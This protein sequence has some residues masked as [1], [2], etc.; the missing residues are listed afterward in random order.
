MK[1]IIAILVFAFGLLST[2][3]AKASHFAA[4]D[5]WYEYLSPLTYKVHVACYLDCEIGNATYFFSQLCWWSTSACGTG[6]NTPLGLADLDPTDPLNDDTLSQ[7]CAGVPNNCASTASIYPAFKYRHFVKTVV[8]S[9]ACADWNFGVSDGASICTIGNG[10][11]NLNMSV[12]AELNNLIRPINNSPVFTAKPIPYVCLN[13][14]NVYQNGP[15]D[16]DLDSVVVTSVTPTGGG[17][18]NQTNL[19]WGTTG[20]CAPYNPGN[21]FPTVGCSW[22]VDPGTG[23][24]SFTPSALGVYVMSFLAEDYDPILNVKVGSVKRDVQIVVL[25]CASPPPLVLDSNIVVVGGYD[26][27]INGTHVITMCPGSPVSITAMS[28]TSTINPNFYSYANLSNFPAG[29]A[30]YSF[31]NSGLTLDTVTGTFTFT[32]SAT[33]STQ[34]WTLIMTFVDSTCVPGLQP[35][36]LKSYFT[37]VLKVL[38][39]V[40]GGG[41]Y[42]YCPGSAPIQLN[43]SGPPQITGWTWT[44]IPG[45]AGQA[46]I[47]NTNISN[48]IATPSQTIDVVVEGLPIVTGCPNRDTV[49]LNVFSALNLNCG[50]DLSPCAN[51]VVNIAGVSNRAGITTWTPSTYLSSNNTLNTSSTPLSNVQYVCTHIDNFGCKAIDTVNINLLGIR[52][53]INSYATKDTVCKGD[54]LQLFANATPQPCGISANPCSGPTTNKTIGT[55]NIA[56]SLF[57]PFFRDFNAGYRLQIMYRA[58]E[59]LASGVSPGNIKGLTFTVQTNPSNPGT[60]S[61]LGFKIKMGCTP[62]TNLNTTQGFIGGLTP[63]FSINK[64]APVLGANNFNF[65]IGSEYYW[66]G[67]SNLVLDICYDL[68]GAFLGGNASPVFGSYT[69]FNSVLADQDFNGGGCGLPGTTVG[70]FNALASALRPNIRFLHCKANAFSYAWTPASSFKIDT[71]DNP[72]VK[73]NVINGTTVFTVLVKSGT[74]GVC[75]GTDNVTVYV[76]NSGAVSASASDPHLCEPGLTTLIGTPG[77]GTLPPVYACGEEN[78]TTTGGIIPAQIGLASSALQVDAPFTGSDGA[79]TQI[80]IRA[81]ELSLAGYSKATQIETITF[82]VLNKFSTSPFPQ[83]NINMGCTNQPQFAG[84]QGGFLSIGNLKNVYNSN[85]YSTTLG[86]NTI[87]LAKPFL[88]DGVSNLI[89]EFCYGGHT[90]FNDDFLRM[91]NTSWNSMQQESDFQNNGCNIPFT[92]T[93]FYQSFNN[94]NRPTLSFTG[95]QAVDKPFNY[96]WTP[97]LYVYD[98]TKQNTLAY[99]LQN[100]TYTVGLV[101]RTGCKAFDTVQIRIEQHNVEVTPSDTTI[102]LGDVVQ[103]FVK[104][105]GTGNPASSAYVWNTTNGMTKLNDTTVLVS[106][107]SNTQYIV[108]RTDQF[109]CTDQDTSNI[110]IN[111]G[112]QIT[113][114]NGDSLIIPF[115]TEVNLLSTGAYKYSWSPA[116]KLNTSNT[117]NV[118]LAPTESG[119]YYVYGLDANNCGNK[120]SIW[121][122]VNPTNPVYVP[123]AF[124]PNGDGYND[125]FKIQ[126]YKFERVQEFRVFNRFGEEVFNGKNNEGWDGT[127][128]GTKVDMDTY[129]YSIR[130]AYPDGTT[131]VLKGDVILLR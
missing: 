70:S 113:I 116:W 101:N 115:G 79:K 126:N 102:C 30:S 37:A 26:S 40:S 81:A 11:A 67:K 50:P 62:N 98:S 38:P 17:C 88:W 57:S 19:N 74:T 44:V 1:R 80:L 82:D 5:I 15:L 22:T 39:G 85:S 103:L 118:I 27:I 14:P 119:L 130:L 92:G 99:V 54:T 95:K 65:P 48:P 16:V 25:S 51:D 121:I 45:Q 34:Q 83:F 28:Y 90:G 129:M 75:N 6:G 31:V 60:D 24:A 41:P 73:S 32:P 2:P 93:S 131:K 117:N 69:S 35:I 71:V 7:L 123:T 61:L 49:T 91:E 66:D 89:V 64:Y 72:I 55:N 46:N 120:D 124:S 125:I 107:T 108:T 128:R 110:S 112:P 100:T 12:K 106:P 68:P 78:Y 84:T 53:I 96:V 104:G 29:S 20:V 109:G 36:V 52:P 105:S 8:L 87:T 63:V 77:A 111:F 18:T 33:G 21:P 3:Q 97:S 114:L 23:A 10:F 4:A 9:N 42:A 76:D 127:Y 47:S 86:L 56:N 58:D 43:A 122:T 94:F 13:Q 59:L